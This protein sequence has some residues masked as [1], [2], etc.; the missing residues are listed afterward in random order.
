MSPR[1]P[2]TWSVLF[3]EGACWNS[4]GLLGGMIDSHRMGSENSHSEDVVQ[5]GRVGQKPGRCPINSF[6]RNSRR[7]PQ[8]QI[9]S[10]CKDLKSHSLTQGKSR[11]FWLPFDIN[12]PSRKVM[13]PG[14][15]IERITYCSREAPNQNYCTSVT[16]REFVAEN[17]S[18]IFFSL[19]NAKHLKPNYVS[20]SC[21]CS[22]NRDSSCVARSAC[23]RFPGVSQ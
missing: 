10:M 17:Y 22:S 23:H 20:P 2:A 5:S 13:K 4:R 8:M 15:S 9:L 18:M 11:N 12:S 6:V 19:T 7:L 16:R 14:Q 21:L 3:V 1:Q